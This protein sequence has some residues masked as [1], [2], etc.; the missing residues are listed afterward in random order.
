MIDMN[1]FF[2][3]FPWPCVGMFL[4]G[5][6]RDAAPTHNEPKPISKENPQGYE[7]SKDQ[8]GALHQQLTRRVSSSERKP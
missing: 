6:V 1:F 4:R 8:N 7:P 2:R 3:I 5:L